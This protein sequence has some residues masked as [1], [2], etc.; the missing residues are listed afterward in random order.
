MAVPRHFGLVFTTRKSKIRA[1]A[2]VPGGRESEPPQ[3]PNGLQYH[4]EWRSP[5]RAFF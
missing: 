4:D 1:L 2:G 3:A 5:E